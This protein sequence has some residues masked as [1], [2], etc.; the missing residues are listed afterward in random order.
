VGRRLNL[1]DACVPFP[2]FIASCIANWAISFSFITPLIAP[3]KKSFSSAYLDIVDPLFI[4]RLVEGAWGKV[5]VV[6]AAF[7][8]QRSYSGSMVKE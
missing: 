7:G 3:I 5:V 1:A 6:A 4:P 2:N 8:L